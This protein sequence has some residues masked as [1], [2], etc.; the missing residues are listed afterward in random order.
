M[1][2]GEWGAGELPRVRGEGM[3]GRKY[4]AI[5][6]GGPVTVHRDLGRAGK[7]TEERGRRMPRS[8]CWEGRAAP[9]GWVI[10]GR[11]AHPSRATSTFQASICFLTRTF[12]LDQRSSAEFSPVPC[13][14]VQLLTRCPW[15][16]L[17]LN[18]IP[19]SL[20]L[21][22]VHKECPRSAHSGENRHSINP[23][24]SEGG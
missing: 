2:W 22:S 10:C 12:H 5:E 23:S 13:A 18:K 3:T 11:A 9:L 4:G 21:P 8:R 1:S 7:G 6:P 20:N 17:G 24:G 19:P 14:S 16:F 15:I